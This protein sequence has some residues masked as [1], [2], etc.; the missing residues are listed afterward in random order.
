MRFSRADKTIS[1]QED[2][3]PV[4][5]FPSMASGCS[6]EFAN[7]GWKESHR[8]HIS[9][10]T[11]RLVRVTIV[12]ALLSA[13]SG[14]LPNADAPI[15]RTADIGHNIALHYVEEGTGTPVIFVHG[16]LSDG[17]YWVDQIGPFA[18][19]YRAIAYSQ[20]HNY[21][22]SAPLAG[23]EV[24]AVTKALG[25]FEPASRALGIGWRK[26]RLSARATGSPRNLPCIDPRRDSNEDGHEK[27]PFVYGFQRIARSSGY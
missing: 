17:G 16:S 2:T 8:A 20:R 12:L 9:V 3:A 23:W 21:P 27:S 5:E 26:Q 1:A 24:A 22:N 4:V 19:H 13:H 14:T 7:A 25:G 15:I 11:V 6:E 18:K 10:C